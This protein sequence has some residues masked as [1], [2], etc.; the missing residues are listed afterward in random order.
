MFI[1][2]LIDSADIHRARTKL[3]GLVVSSQPGRGIQTRKQAIY[4]QSDEG[5]DGSTGPS[6]LGTW[7]IQPRLGRR[8]S[9]LKEEMALLRPK[10]EEG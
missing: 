4:C 6:G 1:C 8:E 7:D 2:S 3:G 9:F 10:A 5:P